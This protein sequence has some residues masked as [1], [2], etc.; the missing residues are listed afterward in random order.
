MVCL[1][2][3][4]PLEH[5]YRNASKLRPGW[6]SKDVLSQQD[7]IVKYYIFVDLQGESLHFDYRQGYALGK[8]GELGWKARLEQMT[9]SPVS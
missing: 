1:Q 2:G 8:H 7:M 5:P 9:R 3:F 6:C 4:E